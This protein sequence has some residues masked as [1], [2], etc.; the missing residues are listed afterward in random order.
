M[1]AEVQAPGA[2]GEV[3]L[4][5]GGEWREGGTGRADVVDPSTERS[6]G[7]VAL[8]SPADLD[9]ALDAA[10]RAFPGWAATPSHERGAVLTRAA[11]LLQERA[12][13]IALALCAEAG[14]LPVEAAG[15]L[16]R[17]IETLRWNGEEAGR[18]E[19]RLIQGRAPGSERLSVPTPVG[20]VAAFAAWN[21]PAV[22]ASRKLG[23]ALAAGCSVV[24]KAAEQTPRTAAEIVRA[25]AD[26]GL[27]PGVLNL[28]FGDPAAVS[29]HVIPAAD[30]RAVT[31]TGSTAV[32]RQIAA[33][34][35]RG[36]KRAVLELGGHAPVIVCE[37]ADVELAVSATLP[38][39]FGSAGQSCVA[40]S[41]YLVHASLYKELA[42]RFMAAASA[43]RVGAP[44]EDGA[45]LGPVIS[46]RRVGAMERLTADAARRGARVLCGGER[47]E[48]TGFFWPPTV[49][50]DVAADALVMHE[51]PFGPIAAFA[52]FEDLDEAI[53]R[54]NDTDYAF[55]A[56]LFTDS[57]AARARVLRDLRASNLGINQMAPSMPD[58]P[59]GG[60]QD[61]GYGYEGGRDGIHAFQHFRLISEVHAP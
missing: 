56:Y 17:A 32:G 50:A 61:S 8:A 35:A 48:R 37:D 30:V 18:L 39:K 10:T 24:F 34:A 42:E 33:L 11:D 16:G 44:S 25:V 28:V 19:G 23:A 43:L 1:S 3:G 55:A 13:D 7:S 53:A 38:A 15:E 26:A 52:P 22:L 47:L 60:T 41:R 27:P 5:V 46:A 58:A 29:A 6:T 21:F 49:L 57:L 40:P 12:P 20:V 4:F 31:F 36:P 54:A 9:D 51:E 45:Q 2:V 59:L 14:K